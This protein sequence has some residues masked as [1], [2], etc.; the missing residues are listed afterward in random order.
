MPRTS[1]D[2]NCTVTSLALLRIKELAKIS[3]FDDLIPFSAI[4]GYNILKFTKM[5]V[6][7]DTAA[8]QLILFDGPNA[9][10]PMEGNSI[11]TTQ[12]YDSFD[13]SLVSVGCFV[14]E[15]KQFL[16]GSLLGPIIDPPSPQ[17]AQKLEEILGGVA[18]PAVECDIKV[19]V[20][21]TE[22]PADLSAWKG[23]GTN[24]QICRFASSTTNSATAGVF[25]EPTQVQPCALRSNWKGVT[26]M[27][28]T[29]DSSKAINLHGTTGQLDI[30]NVEIV[31]DS[32]V[33]SEIQQL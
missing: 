21:E 19:C 28:F 2:V 32:F 1:S 16:L 10:H 12:S 3:Q 18:D 7:T 20:L 33:F 26:M 5:D 27:D 9:A 24:C 15:G 23:D 13:P 11:G 14:T 17:I 30:G 25:L 4:N 29:V 8:G 22:T 31:I 6:L